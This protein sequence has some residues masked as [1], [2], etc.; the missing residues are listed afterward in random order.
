MSPSRSS[1]VGSDDFD[2]SNLPES[3]M[4]LG[5][6][7][8]GEG[9]VSGFTVKAIDHFPDAE[10]MLNRMLELCR[11]PESVARVR[12]GGGPWQ[13]M[14]GP[15]LLEHLEHEQRETLTIDRVEVPVEESARD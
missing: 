13:S 10:T 11:R 6:A 9:D 4:P 3:D 7:W 1:A 12:F 2:T 14:P 8:A 15:R 5:G